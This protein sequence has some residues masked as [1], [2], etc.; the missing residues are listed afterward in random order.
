VHPGSSAR[1][2]IPR[3][4]AGICSTCTTCCLCT[5]RNTACGV[6]VGSQQSLLYAAG[7]CSTPTSCCRGAFKN[8]ACGVPVGSRPCTRCAEGTCNIPTTCC[9]GAYIKTTV[10]MISPRHLYMYTPSRY[11]QY[12]AQASIPTVALVRARPGPIRSFPFGAP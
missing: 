5:F 6:P 7:T 3:Y 10:Y 11:L 8:T 4:A 2:I 12:I 9:L 1:H